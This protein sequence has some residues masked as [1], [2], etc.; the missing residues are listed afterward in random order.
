M[1]YKMQNSCPQWDSNPVTSAYEANATIALR[2]LI[3]IEWLNVYWILPEFDT[4]F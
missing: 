2:G 3:Y 4:F 1:N